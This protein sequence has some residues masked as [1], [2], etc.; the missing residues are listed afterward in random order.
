MLI[1]IPAAMGLMVLARPVVYVLYPQAGTLGLVA[2]LLRVLAV[3]VV[4]YGLST[5]SNGV[6]QGTGYVNRPVIHAAAALVVQ[7]AVLVPLLLW[8]KADLYALAAA[9][10]TYSFCMCLFNGLSMRKKLRYRQEMVKTFL[11]PTIASL[12]MGVVAW[13]AYQGSNSLFILSGALEKGEMN[14]L[15]NCICLI[16]AIGLALPTYF[17]LVVKLGAVGKAELAAMPG[18][19]TL[20]S[21]GKKLHL[22]R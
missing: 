19:R 17:A 14:W 20:V 15:Y 2:G 16:P 6:L 4:F 12:P 18:G 5:L 3:S 9:A 11:I 8:T 1:S 13:L 21:I 10:I 22:L 7:T